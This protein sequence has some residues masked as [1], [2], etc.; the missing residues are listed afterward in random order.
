MPHADIYRPDQVRTL[1][2]QRPHLRPTRQVQADARKIIELVSAQCSLELSVLLSDTRTQRVS[3]VRWVAM[4]LLNHLLH[5]SST[6][7]GTA[8]NRDH[9]TILHGLK[10]VRDQRTADPIYA[11]RLDGVAREISDEVLGACGS[12]PKSGRVGDVQ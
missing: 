9:T 6:E 3:Q 12:G 7:I 8:L 11:E 4:Y 5:M 1:R 10:R 2:Y